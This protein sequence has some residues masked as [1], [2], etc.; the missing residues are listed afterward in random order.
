MVIEQ[1]ES[2]LNPASI[3]VVGVSDN[4]LSMGYNFLRYLI[5][6]GYPNRVIP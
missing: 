4:S 1:I 3:A 6:Y 5:D 2:A